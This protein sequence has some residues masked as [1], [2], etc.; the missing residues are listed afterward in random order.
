MYENPKIKKLLEE[1]IRTIDIVVRTALNELSFN[2]YITGR[3][4][5]I[6]GDGTYLVTIDEK[7][8]SLK[9]KE[10]VTL[11]SGDIV[12][13]MIP[14]SQRSHAFIDCKRPY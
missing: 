6:N 13:I 1:V 3:I 4:K 9:A 11:T 5:T 8:E 10:G 2:Y 7:D 12:L 14:N